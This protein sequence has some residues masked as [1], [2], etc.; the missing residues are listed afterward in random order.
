MANHETNTWM[1]GGEPYKV[2][3]GEFITSLNSLSRETGYSVSIVRNTLEKFKKHDFLTYQSTNK[4]RLVKI[5]NWGKY[6]DKKQE[7]SK[8]DNKHLASNS[9]AVSKHLATNKN[10]RI[11]ESFIINNSEKNPEEKIEEFDNNT[12]P[13]NPFAKN[14]FTMLSG[15]GMSEDEFK[16]RGLEKVSNIKDYSIALN[17]YKDECEGRNGNTTGAQ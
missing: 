5:S 11:K 6:Q 9:Q 2:E 12:S 1:F 14:L 13:L 8:Q 16:N 4:N 17:S 3:P 15:Y 10:E 7:D